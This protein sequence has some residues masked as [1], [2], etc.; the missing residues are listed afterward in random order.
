[1]NAPLLGFDGSG[2]P[3]PVPEKPLRQTNPEENTPREN[4]WTAILNS[5][6]DAEKPMIGFG[7][8]GRPLQVNR[9]SI[10]F[11]TPPLEDALNLGRL[12]LD[13]SKENFDAIVREFKNFLKEGKRQLKEDW[14]LLLLDLKDM[15]GR[16]I[17]VPNPDP[18]ID[19]SRYRIDFDGVDLLTILAG[20]LRLLKLNLEE[21]KEKLGDDFDKFLKALILSL[22]K[23]V[24]DIEI[25]EGDFKKILE[26]LRKIISKLD[27]KIQKQ[28][29]EQIML[30]ITGYIKAEM[31]K[32]QEK[33]VRDEEW[34]QISPSEREA[35]IRKFS[36]DKRST[37]EFLE[38]N[39]SVM[40]KIINNIQKTIENLSLEAKNKT[41]VKKLKKLISTL[42]FILAATS[43]QQTTARNNSGT[44][45]RVSNPQSSYVDTYS[46]SQVPE[47]QRIYQ[48]TADQSVSEKPINMLEGI[49]ITSAAEALEELGVSVGAM[50]G[51][52][53]DQILS[54]E[55]K[56]TE[57]SVISILNN[58]NK[59]PMFLI[60]RHY[61]DND[62]NLVVEPQYLDSGY[63][64]IDDTP[65]LNLE[66][67]SENDR[68]RLQNTTEYHLV[69]GLY[70]EKN[71]V[72][73][74]P[75]TQL[76]E[77]YIADKLN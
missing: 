11:Q 58:K 14:N 44:G 37:E 43:I 18:Y 13:I 40:E 9:E 63:G 52:R 12:V 57:E 32:K 42:L 25:P 74:T 47:S 67:L 3:L 28:I 59:K 61:F 72:I 77:V 38:A 75:F 31:N 16:D 71:G 35:I 33:E 29:Y 51:K 7:P 66:L 76:G 27:P 46:S 56:S 2:R 64:V 34:Y 21:L 62:G 49:K 60:I 69:Y 5:L 15:F 53:G 8:D 19:Y 45:E 23:N 73:T 54:I 39:R 6:K 30:A 70:E 65:V 1:M 26:E 68:R 17:G 50:F 22:D 24:I 20:L 4:L 55:N 10:Q 48:Q 41:E 36:I